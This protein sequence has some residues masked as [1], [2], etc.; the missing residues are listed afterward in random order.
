SIL[1][2]SARQD[3]RTK[4]GFRMSRFKGAIAAA[5]L[6]VG[7]T[8]ANA[9]VL[10]SVDL[11]TENQVSI[12]ATDGFSSATVSGSDGIGV[13]FA[14]FYN[15]SGTGVFS[16]ILI[17]GALT[18]AEN[19]SDGSPALFRGTD[20]TGLNL[21]SFAAGSDA[22][23]TAGSLAFTGEAT[24]ALNEEEYMAMLGNTGSGSLFFPADT[25]DD[26][27]GAT[28]IGEWEVLAAD[29]PAPAPL[30]LLGLGLAAIC[31]RRKL[32]ARD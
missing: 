21:F 24:W 26:V 22:S 17:S 13:Y 9:A 29:V 20:D 27:A 12:F 31:A 8:G 1:H 32:V 7:A 15:E 11:S 28:L 14:G 3:S 6:L 2:S 23:F 25:A 18:S 5:T 10:L 19:T 16:D 4:R 30:G